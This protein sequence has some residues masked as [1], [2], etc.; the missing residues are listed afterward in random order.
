MPMAE[1]SARRVEP[2]VGVGV[3]GVG[4]MGAH[5]AE[6]LALR[7]PGARLVGLADPMPGVAERLAAALGSQSWTT[8]YQQLL[9]DPAVEAV[10]I[11]TP[12]RYHADAIVAAAQAG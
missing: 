2:P 10:V 5:H 8:D 12:A 1:A 6:S 11:A 7:V 9:A 4:T 3:I